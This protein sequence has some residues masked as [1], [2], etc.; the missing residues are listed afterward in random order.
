MN[1]ICLVIPVLNQE[2]N[3]Q[4]I[5]NKIKKIKTK[6]DILFIED[7]STDGGKYLSVALNFLL[8]PAVIIV[9]GILFSIAASFVFIIA[10]IGLIITFLAL[11]S[12]ED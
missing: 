6:L 7:N 11:V 10:E 9:G 12:S 5:Y 2:K 4:K 3:I 1:K 8:I